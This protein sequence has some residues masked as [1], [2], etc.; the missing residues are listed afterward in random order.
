MALF[1]K[2]LQSLLKAVCFILFTLLYTFVQECMYMKQMVDRA[3]GQ[4]TK[5]VALFGLSNQTALG[6][7]NSPTWHLSDLGVTYD[8]VITLFPGNEV[9]S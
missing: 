8:L 1:L 7:G 6:S 9:S 3:I 4:V 2:R 5:L